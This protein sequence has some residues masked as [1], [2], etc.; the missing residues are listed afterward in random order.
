MAQKSLL[1]KMLHVHHYLSCSLNMSGSDEDGRE[2][3][4]GMRLTF[5]SPRPRPRPRPWSGRPRP[6]PVVLVFV[7]GPAV[8]E[9]VAPGL[10]PSPVLLRPRP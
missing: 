3:C 6:H 1:F 8:L 4:G 5:T 2:R 7:L 9:P 10:I